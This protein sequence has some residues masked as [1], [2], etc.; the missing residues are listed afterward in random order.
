DAAGN[1]VVDDTG[2]GRLRTLSGGVF[3]TFAGGYLGDG[4]PA[5]S[6]ALVRPEALAIDKSG[7][8]YIADGNGNRVRKVSGGKISTVAGTSVNGYSGDGGPATSALLN[9]PLGVAVG[10]SGNVFI[11]DTS[12]GVIRK[13]NTSGNISTFASNS[14][15]CYLLQ[16]A[17]DSA[18]NVYVADQCTSVIFKITPAGVV[19]VF[20]GVPFNYGYNGD[21]IPATTA[22]LSNPWG[23][24][25]DKNGNVFIADTYNSRVREVNTA[26]IIST[27]AGDG[28]CNY[29][30]DG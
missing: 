11:A 4:N 7:N 15:F 8:L 30:G 1:V 27:I 13:V 28:T 3:S 14:N 20:A 12:N 16:M 18:N 6:A 25:V 5:T 2:N 19:S 26:G 24:A 17:T 21:N 10:S 29:T 9:H 23:V 22:W